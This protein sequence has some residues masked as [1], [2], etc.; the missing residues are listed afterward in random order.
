MAMIGS[1][2]PKPV[3][4]KSLSLAEIAGASKM[5]RFILIHFIVPPIQSGIEFKA[6]QLRPLDHA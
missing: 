6:R 1:L 3:F 5:P 4:S 2:E